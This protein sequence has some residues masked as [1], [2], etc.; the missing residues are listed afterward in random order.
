MLGFWQHT[1]VYFR[2]SRRK[3]VTRYLHDPKGTIAIWWLLPDTQ[4]E[5]LSFIQERFHEHLLNDKQAFS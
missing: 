1:S 2:Y 3:S 4:A 5:V